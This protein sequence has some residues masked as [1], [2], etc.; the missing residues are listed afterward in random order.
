MNKGCEKTG[1]WPLLFLILL[2]LSCMGGEQKLPAN[3]SPLLV[4]EV[5]GKAVATLQDT[6]LLKEIAKLAP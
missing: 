6:Q 5:R 1:M 2:A 3:Q 4:G